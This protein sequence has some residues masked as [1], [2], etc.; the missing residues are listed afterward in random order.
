MSLKTNKSGSN[1]QGEYHA[2]IHYTSGKMLM[3]LLYDPS[4]NGTT[5]KGSYNVFQGKQFW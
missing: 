3:V 1:I 5:L 2:V 4:H